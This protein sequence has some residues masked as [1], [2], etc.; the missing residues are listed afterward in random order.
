MLHVFF[1]TTT[2]DSV[3]TGLAGSAIGSFTGSVSRWLPLVI[4]VHAAATWLMVGLVWFIQLVHYPLFSRYGR[5]DFPATAQLHAARTTLIV[6]PAMFVELA[7]SVMLVILALQAQE[8]QPLMLYSIVGA[9]LLVGCWIS[10]FLVQVPMHAKLALGF[11]GG[12]HRKLVATN[13]V[14]T[15]CWTARGVV[16]VLMLLWAMGF[17]Q[18]RPI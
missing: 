16:A 15:V 5:A 7:A 6:A 2:F 14:R 1:A 18:V 9:A 17:N 12:V 4:S 10:T 3:L 13:W 11:N 8:N